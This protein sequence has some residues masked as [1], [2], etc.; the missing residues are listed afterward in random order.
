MVLPCAS[1]KAWWCAKTLRIRV[2][3]CLQFTRGLGFSTVGLKTRPDEE[4]LDVAVSSNT[5]PKT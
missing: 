4:G 3:D 1:E 5:K 2:F